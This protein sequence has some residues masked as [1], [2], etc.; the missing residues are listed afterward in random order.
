MS[1]EMQEKRSVPRVQPFVTPC[2]VVDGERRFS[3]YVLDLSS[4]G[5]KVSCAVEPPAK[6]S[7]VTLEVRLG[8][9]TPFF[10]YNAEV[11]WTQ[12]PASRGAAHTFGVTF[13]DVATEQRARLETVLGEFRKLAAAIE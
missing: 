7:R 2:R 8:G 1:A 12:P 11:R 3:G 13:E 5:A 10:P 4:Q 6:G 9:R